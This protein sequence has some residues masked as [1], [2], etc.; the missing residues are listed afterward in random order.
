MKTTIL[1]SAFLA[2]SNLK[3]LPTLLQ[4][5]VVRDLYQAAD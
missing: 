2:L 1:T 4:D 5:G 3:T